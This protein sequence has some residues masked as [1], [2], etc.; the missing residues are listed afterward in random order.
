MILILFVPKGAALRAASDAVP[1]RTPCSIKRRVLLV[2]PPG[3]R[4]PNWSGSPRSHAPEL[5]TQPPNDRTS[6][7]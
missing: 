1:H 3:S 5:M 4:V 6:R 7:P 2:L